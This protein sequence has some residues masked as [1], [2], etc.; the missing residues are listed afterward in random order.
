MPKFDAFK[1]YL[2]FVYLLE[3]S[4]LMSKEQ[5]RVNNDRK[6]ILALN[7]VSSILCMYRLIGNEREFINGRVGPFLVIFLPTVSISF[8]KLRFRRSF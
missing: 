3:V 1:M 8:T 7:F 4:D 2:E 6:L 5:K